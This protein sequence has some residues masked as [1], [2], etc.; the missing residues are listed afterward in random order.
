M[1]NNPHLET[2][3]G[4]VSQPCCASKTPIES[5]PDNVD[6]KGRCIKHPNVKLFK[7]KILGGYYEMIKDACPQCEEEA[8][9]EEMWM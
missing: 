7:K 2:P 9:Y 1:N 3:G 5:L 6:K 4:S 8:P